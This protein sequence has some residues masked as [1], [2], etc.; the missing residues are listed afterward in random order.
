VKI[1]TCLI[2][3]EELELISGDGV[4]SKEV[5]CNHCGYSSKYNKEHEPEVIIRRKR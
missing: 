5:K 3:E 4:M 2:C 1:L